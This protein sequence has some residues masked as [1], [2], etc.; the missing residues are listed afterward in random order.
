MFTNIKIF[1]RDLIPLNYQVPLKFWFLFFSC[2]LE[3]E[4]H[5]L[6]RIVKP[7]ERVIDVGANRGIYTYKL[8]RLGALVEVFEPNPTCLRILKAWAYDKLR[9]KIHPIALSNKN[10]SAILN[11][12]VDKY[13][14]EHDASASLEDLKFNSSR[15][16]SVSLLTLDSFNFQ[17]V[18]MIKIDVEGHELSVLEGAKDTLSR[19][20]PALIIEIEQRHNFLPFDYLILKL[21]NLGYL[22][23]F[24]Y[25]DKLTP[26]KEFNLTVHQSMKNF[27][28]KNGYYINNFL[29]LHSDKIK[30]GDY[31]SVLSN[32]HI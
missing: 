31:F 9:V 19:W 21:I 12:P 20:K 7:Y 3:K 11:V 5:L 10:G 15:H 16:E 32:Y 30:K 28:S 2:G 17:E 27:N 4:M 29:F 26:L 18:S 25:N 6:R 14:I 24:I 13:G 22:G 8:W 23:Y 1:I